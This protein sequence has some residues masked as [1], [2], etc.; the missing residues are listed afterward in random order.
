MRHS[1]QDIVW[2]DFESFYSNEYSLRKKKYNLSS[3][4]RDPQFK[5]HCIAIRD[6]YKGASVWYEARDIKKALKKHAIA[7]RPVCAHNTA[8]DG[9]VLSEVYGV[10]CPYYYD[11]LSMARGLHGTLTRN[12]LDT[13]GLLYGKGGKK[14]NVLRKAKGVRNLPTDLLDLL[15]DYCAND[16]DVCA[17][18]AYEQLQV[19]PDKEL[20]LIDW[21]I[22]CFVDPVLYVDQA[23]AKAELDEQ[24]ALK[25]GKVQAAA[26]A[27]ALLQSADL[28][29]EALR[30][31]GVEP[32]LKISK[33]TGE[34]TYAFS[35]TD[36][37]FTDMLKWEERP[38]VVR[39]V[40]ARLAIKSSI[41]ETRAQRFIDIGKRTL[42]VGNNYCGAHTT[43]WSGGNKMNLQ[44]LPR[45]EYDDQ[46][47]KIEGTGRLRESI[48][49]PPGHVILVSDSGQIEAR[50]NGWFS[51]QTDLLDA[52]RLYDTTK[53][54]AYDPYRIQASINTGK[55]VE[56]ISKGE[57]FVGKVCTLALGYQMGAPRL[58]ATLALGMMGPP[59][60]ITDEQAQTYVSA[61]RNKND[62]I[63]LNWKRCESIL[64]DMLMGRPGRW[65]CIEWEGNSIWLPT[66]L[67]L[68]YY[69][70]QGIPH[71][72]EDRYQ[73]YIYLERNKAIKTY[74]GK[75]TENIIQALGRCVISD[76]LLSINQQLP[77]FKTRSSEVCRVVS[78]THDE[79]I[80]VVPFKAAEKAQE[81]LLTEMRRTPL[82]ADGLPLFSE[83]GFDIRYSK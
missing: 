72:T 49:A 14:P 9:L 41:G 48:I 5:A 82:W 63:V 30:S 35:K 45:P 59:V 36:W 28:F 47:N 80:A 11:T 12:D 7:S 44:N 78:M 21:T 3:Y 2:I 43:R 81:L 61:Y 20:D 1:L 75:L 46:G 42:P 65:K 79:I 56:D 69:H 50:L 64:I 22:R 27:P 15:G 77:Q 34:L 38:D 31:L 73:E 53:N 26:I 52:F 25:E 8:F 55:P 23:Y 33:T 18:I 10:V 83:G 57:R 13:V 6:G 71:P 68:H 76:Q 58:Q 29:A 62:K 40:E 60:D 54:K 32:P 74:G 24:I 39:L 4:V 17:E 37:Q 67:G 70:L 51:D 16:N 66:G 19:Y